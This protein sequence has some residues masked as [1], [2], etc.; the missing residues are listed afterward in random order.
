MLQQSQNIFLIVASLLQVT[1]AKASTPVPTTGTQTSASLALFPMGATDWGWSGS[2]VGCS[3]DTTYAKSACTLGFLTAARL[4][5]LLD[6]A[7]L[8][9]KFFVLTAIN[10]ITTSYILLLFSVSSN[11][12]KGCFL[13]CQNLSPTILELAIIYK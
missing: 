11:D 1:N 3:T 12:K 2:C 6:N 4:K 13:L 10:N 8:I 5:M 9:I 7:L